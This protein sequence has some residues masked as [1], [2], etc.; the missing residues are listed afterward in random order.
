MR[1]LQIAHNKLATAAEE[2]ALR[3]GHAKHADRSDK[4][5]QILKDPEFAGVFNAKRTSVNLKDKCVAQ[6]ACRLRE[7]FGLTCAHSLTHFPA[8]GA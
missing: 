2:A 4:W 6:R 8:G 7:R 3:K 5:A 1:C